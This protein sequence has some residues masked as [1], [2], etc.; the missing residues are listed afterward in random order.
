MDACIIKKKL[1]RSFSVT[2]NNKAKEI[3][4]ENEVERVR[5]KETSRKIGMDAIAIWSK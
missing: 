3:L 1:N 2:L 4:F 5:Y